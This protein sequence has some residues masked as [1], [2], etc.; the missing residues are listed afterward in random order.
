MQIYRTNIR[1]GIGDGYKGRKWMSVNVMP[2][3]RRAYMR[4]IYHNIG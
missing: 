2:N 3:I 4:A 1:I